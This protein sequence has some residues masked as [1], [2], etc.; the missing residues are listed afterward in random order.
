MPR[1][2]ST[3]SRS[4]RSRTAKEKAEKAGLLDLL[5]SD[6]PFEAV[7][8]Q[9]A[10][11]TSADRGDRRDRPPRRDGDGG[12]RTAAPRH[13]D[14]PP[15]QRRCDRPGP[16]V[17]SGDRPGWRPTSWQHATR[18]WPA[19][20]ATQSPQL[21]RAA[22]A[23]AAAEAEAAQARPRPPQRGARRPSRGAAPRR[24][25]RPAGRPPGRASGR[26]RAERPAEGRGQARGARGRSAVDGRGSAA[27]S[28]ASPNGSTVPT[29]PRP[30]STSSTCATCAASS[31]PARIRWSPATSRPA[32]SPPS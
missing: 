14:R 20:R 30:T 27:A 12:D 10:N 16:T 5:P 23:A 17:P 6:K 13:R 31:P 19:S 3:A 8:Q 21:H 7:T 26:Q 29:R 9:L 1:S 11:A 15:R 18:A 25:A 2:S 28:C 4:C 22:R 32:R 24:R